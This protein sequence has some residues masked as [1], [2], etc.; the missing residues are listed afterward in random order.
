MSN[1]RWKMT[2]LRT[3]LSRARCQPSDSTPCFKLLARCLMNPRRSH[4]RIRRV[5]RAGKDKNERTRNRPAT[6]YKLAATSY[7]VVIL[8]SSSL[9][10]EACGKRHSAFTQ[11][12]CWTKIS[13]NCKDRNSA[14]G[15]HSNNKITNLCTALTKS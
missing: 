5:T 3:V 8:W 2:V 10:K 6:T 12:T 15:H 11:P 1:D 14:A 4:K 7:L 9:A 13:D